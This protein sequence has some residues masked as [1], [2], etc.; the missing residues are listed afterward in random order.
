MR[1]N[2]YGQ[3]I[4]SKTYFPGGLKPIIDRCC[5]ELGLKSASMMR[6]IP[7]KAYEMNLPIKGTTFKARDIADNNPKNNCTWCPTITA[8]TCRSRALRMV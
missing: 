6:G 1:L 4:P 3:V 8:W 2:E 7:R 5:H